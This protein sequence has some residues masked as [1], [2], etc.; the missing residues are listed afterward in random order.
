ML[1]VPMGWENALPWWGLAFGIGYLL[2]S[3]PFGIFV[4]RVFALG[5]LR[6][7][8][9]GNIGATNVLRTGNKAAAALT[10][11][12]DMAKG[13][14]P[15]WWFLGWGDIA[16][17]AAGIGAVLG[18]CLP[19]WLWFRGGKGV[20][21]FIGVIL[22]LNPVAGAA[23]CATWLATALVSRFSSLAALLASLAAPAC[24]WLFDGPRAIICAALLSIF[25]WAR[26]HQNIRRLIAG[27]EPRIGASKGT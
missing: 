4:S 27:E 25:I 6:S 24:L 23:V 18:H 26:H 1:H 3:V 14:L 12:A 10:L 19:I 21:T 22:A 13:F 11:L 5:D 7:I 15:V 2:G 9:S 16:G 8:G 17:Q 20:A